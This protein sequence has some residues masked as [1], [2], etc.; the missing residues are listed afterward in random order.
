MNLAPWKYRNILS[1]DGGPVRKIEAQRL[2]SPILQS[3]YEAYAE[4]DPKVLSF[5]LVKDAKVYGTADGNGTSL[6]LNQARYKSISEALERW[7]FYELAAS[8]R[9]DRFGFSVDRSTTGMAAF[10]G[11]T[12]REVSDNAFFEAIERWS[13]CAWWEG[14]L[15]SSRLSG[16][17][18]AGSFIPVGVEIKIDHLFSS[19]PVARKRTASVVLLWHRIPGRERVCYG[20]SCA[21]SVEKAIQRASVELDRNRRVLS[22]LS[23]SSDIS[24]IGEKR[25]VFFSTTEGHARFLE[26]VELSLKDHSVISAPP[27]LVTNGLIPGPWENYCHVWRCLFEPVSPEHESGRVDYFLF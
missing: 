25:L 15:R 2:T 7:A 26:R 21:S 16:P 8:Q 6:Y 4:L 3:V 27:K 13:L 22:E 24:E 11:L 9:T 17:T 18:I 19:I 1:A 23:P 12:D 14:K 10:P 5:A 20:F